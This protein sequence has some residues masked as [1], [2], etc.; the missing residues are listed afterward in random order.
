MSTPRALRLAAQMVSLA[1]NFHNSSHL[2][3]ELA[4]RASKVGKVAPKCRA[5]LGDD[6]IFALR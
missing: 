6:Q 1:N 4:S 5:Q 2:N 3:C